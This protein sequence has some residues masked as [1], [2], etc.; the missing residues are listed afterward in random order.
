MSVRVYTGPHS[1][2]GRPRTAW[3]KALP[4]GFLGLALAMTILATFTD[5]TL[6]GAAIAVAMLL[7]SAAAATHAV[8][9]RGWAWAAG[10]LAITVGSAFV[11]ENLSV[12]RAFPFGDLEYGS[13]LG[14]ALFGVPVTVV[15]VWLATT[16]PVLLAAQRMS[17]ERLTTAAIGAVALAA[18]DLLWDPLFT[19]NGH[20]TWS[21]GTWTLPGLSPLPLQDPLGWLLVGFLLILALDRLPRKT[22]K[23]GVPVTMLSWLFVWGLVVNIVTLHSLSAVAWG[24][25]GLALLVLPWW[26]RVWSEPQW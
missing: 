1:D 12:H 13:S 15:L 19:A 22:A 2:R 26:W 8:V 4:W 6:Q 7:A 20:V 14:P 9:A 23:D 3:Q 11:V 21:A 16:Y 18:M 17:E 5:G 10:F 25:I 24:G